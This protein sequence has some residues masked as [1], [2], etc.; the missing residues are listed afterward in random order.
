MPLSNYSYNHSTYLECFP[1]LKYPFQRMYRCSDLIA[2]RNTNIIIQSLHMHSKVHYKHWKPIQISL[3]KNEKLG[4]RGN[5]KKDIVL[6]HE[7]DSITILLSYQ[8]IQKHLSHP[9]MF[10]QDVYYTALIS[11]PSYSCSPFQHCVIMTPSI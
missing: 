2:L 10:P 6:I 7:D 1:L 8:E 11:Y 9:K 4:I 5:S 3:K